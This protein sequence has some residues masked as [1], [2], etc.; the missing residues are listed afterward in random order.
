M[1][2]KD[3][4]KE[5]FTA[6]PH[7]HPPLLRTYNRPGFE[8]PRDLRILDWAAGVKGTSKELGENNSAERGT[9]W[10]QEVGTQARAGLAR[11]S[12]EDQRVAKT[13][14]RFQPR[15]QQLKAGCRLG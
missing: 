1:K 6:T 2:W 10:S 14:I 13:L 7:H 5:D 12:G 4:A 11:G 9:A 8:M 15:R 3:G